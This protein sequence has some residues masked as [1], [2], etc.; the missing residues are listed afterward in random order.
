MGDAAEVIARARESVSHFLDEL[1]S[2]ELFEE[3]GP[4][5][6]DL[7]KEQYAKKQ[8]PYGEAWDPR[9]GD[10]RRTQSTYKFGKVAEVERDGFSLI[11]ARSNAKRSCVPFEPRG[12]GRWQPK[13]DEIVRN[14]AR[15][16]FRNV[17]P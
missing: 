16:L 15:L 11:V 10:E 9:P 14:R 2:A 12:L 6:T 5:A 13:F 4:A 7:Y 1:V 8:N 3:L 17:R